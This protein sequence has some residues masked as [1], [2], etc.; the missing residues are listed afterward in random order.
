MNIPKIV[1]ILWFQGE[2][3]S[4]WIVKRCIKSWQVLN[5]SWKVNILDD[6]LIHQYL[7][8]YQSPNRLPKPQQSD[9]IRL[10]L[11]EK[12]GGVWADA[13]TLCNKPLDDWLP[14][15]TTSN[16]FV[17]HLPGKDRLISSWFIASSKNN[18]LINNLLVEFTAYWQSFNINNKNIENK[19]L[20]KI[21]SRLF[22]RN[23]HSTKHWFGLIPRKVL[24]VYPYYALHY[25]FADLVEKDNE[26]RAIWQNTS[27]V[28]ADKPHKIQRMGLYTIVTDE[29]LEQIAQDEP[30]L[31]KLTYKYDETKCTENSLLKVIINKPTKQ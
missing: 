21:L 18:P 16:F 1:W 26:C 14:A 8:N 25:F 7:P 20:M 31:Y 17:Y 11:L 19:L 9:I 23:T 6:E 2:V 10:E 12:Y 29:L 3:N 22:N 28:S 15:V 27:K 30:P 13:T 24:G 5:P 4:P